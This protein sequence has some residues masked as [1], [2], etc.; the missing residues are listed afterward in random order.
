[1]K[2]TVDTKDASM[3]HRGYE[4]VIVILRDNKSVSSLF[5]VFVKKIDL[6]R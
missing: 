6:R 4:G 5:P 1:M 2:M 3:G